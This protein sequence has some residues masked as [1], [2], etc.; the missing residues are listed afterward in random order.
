MKTTRILSA[1]AAALGALL[2]SGAAASAADLL[3]ISEYATMATARGQ[4]APIT[5]APSIA[6]QVTSDFTAAAVQ[7]SAFNSGTNFVRLFCTVQC[8]VTFGT[9]PTATANNTIL[10]ASTPEY[11]GVPPGQSFKVSVHTNP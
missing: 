4:L 10:P 7:S 9:N 3:Y 8:S 6:D 2:F 11:F 5:L 1:L